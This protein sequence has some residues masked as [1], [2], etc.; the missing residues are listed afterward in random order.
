M[1]VCTNEAPEF[2]RA[3]REWMLWNVDFWFIGHV[4]YGEEDGAFVRMMI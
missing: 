4:L 2:T 3:E 1:I